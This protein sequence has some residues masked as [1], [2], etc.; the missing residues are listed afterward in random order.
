VRGT[1]FIVGVKPGGATSLDVVSG[2][3]A[4][5]P[6]DPSINNVD[7]RALENVVSS[8]TAVMVE[9]GFSSEVG[10]G[11]TKAAE[12]TPI[13][14]SKLENLNSNE[15]A[16]TQSTP[17][18]TN[19]GSESKGQAKEDKSKSETAK[20]DNKTPN[21]TDKSK[22]KKPDEQSSGNSTAAKKEDAPKQDA[23]KTASSGSDNKPGPAPAPA[24]PVAAVLPPG[25]SASMANAAP[26]GGG[27][28]GGS[29]DGGR[30]PASMGPAPM[31]G[32]APPPPPQGGN[33]QAPPPV[34][35]NMSDVQ[36]PQ[37]KD[38]CQCYGIGCNVA[39]AGGGGPGGGGGGA[40]GNLDGNALG[41]ISNQ[42]QSN[43]SDAVG[44]GQLPSTATVKFNITTQ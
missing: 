24:A 21:D 14:A 41:T 13:P 23:P 1:D 22:D 4:M 43:I 16:L 36:A 11:A 42:I 33:F 8:P 29:D 30:S 17:S 25:L 9:K 19:E 38:L 37:C 34:Q 32:Q 28:G 35:V 20:A 27:G 2:I 31:G 40:V 44:S 15:N 7:Q 12:P 10:A 26:V 5:A 39:A 18:A 3:V 6:I